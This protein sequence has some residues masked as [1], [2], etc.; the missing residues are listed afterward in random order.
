MRY[1]ILPASVL[2]EAVRA[3]MAGQ[4]DEVTAFLGRVLETEGIY[5]GPAPVAEIAEEQEDEEVEDDEQE[6]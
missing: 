2:F 3:K 5:S 4:D 1:C 6:P